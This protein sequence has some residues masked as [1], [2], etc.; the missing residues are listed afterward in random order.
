MELPYIMDT[1]FDLL[2]E[3]ENLDVKELEEDEAAGEFRLTTRD[4]T[5]VQL[6]CAVL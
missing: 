2:N 1:L 3:S 5:R 6:R 4:E